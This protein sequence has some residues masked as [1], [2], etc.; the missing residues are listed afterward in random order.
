MM[1]YWRGR[2]TSCL[3]TDHHTLDE[4]P[5]DLVHICQCC[6]LDWLVPTREGSKRF[7]G[8]IARCRF[9]VSSSARESFQERWMQHRP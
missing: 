3:I 7:H 1:Y 2:E 9:G 6:N 5:M 4:H 8:R